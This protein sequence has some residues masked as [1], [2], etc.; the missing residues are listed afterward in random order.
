MLSIY[1]KIFKKLI[2]Y[3]ITLLTVIF[4]KIFSNIFRK[5]NICK[6]KVNMVL[7]KKDNNKIIKK[8][9]RLNEL[10]NNME[11]LI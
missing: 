6:Y 3:I 4:K 2:L 10:K 1:Y 11:G 8:S 5:I 9:D 7:F